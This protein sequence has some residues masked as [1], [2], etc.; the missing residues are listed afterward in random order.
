MEED[1]DEVGDEE[2]ANVGAVIGVG[3]GEGVEGGGFGRVE[4]PVGEG[5]EEK[6]E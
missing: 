3:G 5:A 4:V 6:G 2:G 1:A